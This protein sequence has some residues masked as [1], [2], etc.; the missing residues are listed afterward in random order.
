M[1]LRLPNRRAMILVGL[2]LVL[3]AAAFASIRLFG[4]LHSF[5][6]KTGL[7]DVVGLAENQADTPGTLAYKL[8]HGQRV[9]IL[10]LGYGGPGHGGAFLTDSI[11]VVSVQGVDRIAMTS[12]PRDS[13]VQIPA[14]ANGQTYDGKINA[15]YEIPLSNGAFG[16][17]SPEYDQGYAGA[18]KLASKVVGAYIGQPIDYWLGVDFTAFKQAVD[19][20]GG[21]DVVNP[22]VLDDSTYPLGETNGYE[23]IHFNAGRL[24]LSG[25]Q[26]LIYVRERHADSDFGRSRRQQQV[27]LA[28]KDKALSLGG[29]P[30]F[31]DL[32]SAL[33]DHVKTNMTPADMRTFSSVLDKVHDA[34]THHVSVDNTTL[35]YDTYCC[36]GQYI[37]LPR[38]HTGATLHQYIANELPPAN[39]LNEKAQVQ[40]ASSLH[41]AS[42]GQSLAGVVGK[43]FGMIGFTT[44]PPAT[45]STTPQ[46]TVV[47]DY[48]GGAAKATVAWL[49]QY[50]HADVVTET[51][52]A[53]PVA[54]ASPSPSGSPA[55]A[56]PLV[57]VDLGLDYAGPF[58]TEETPQYVAPE[59]SVPSTYVPRRTPTAA[60]T[61][62]PSPTPTTVVESPSPSPT[63]PLQCHPKN[64][65]LCVTP[66]PTTPASPTS[67]P[68]GASSPPAPTP[69]ASPKP[70]P[71]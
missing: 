41:E 24:H 29:L 37:L 26:A 15:A 39:A 42:Q 46:T 1:A 44:L 45:L 54:S 60:P 55:A 30:H 67:S 5:N 58:D 11:M 63:P 69:S 51:P 19:A 18:G 31:F 14:F 70:T 49:K 62:A 25:D 38:D 34:S 4:L 43:M 27:L 16:R 22:Y 47:H 66:S 21:V 17:V 40:F 13:F 48:S 7:G 33:Q 52:S 10:L 9:N 61:Q 53:A 28:I 8:K 71:T 6:P 2:A 50:F 20:V 32:L 64:S 3:A 56:G 12:I 57:T 68:S 35:Q 59:Q 36:G 65:P 23:H